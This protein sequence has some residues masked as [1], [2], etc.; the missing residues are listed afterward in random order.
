MKT[1]RYL[2]SLQL[3]PFRSHRLHLKGTLA[4]FGARNNPSFTLISTSESDLLY[5]P[6]PYHRQFL[7]G[8]LLPAMKKNKQAHQ[9]PPLQVANFIQCNSKRRAASETAEVS[10]LQNQAAGITSMVT[11]SALVL[12]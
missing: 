3:C 12:L 4:F 6:I 1:V 2:P 8:R 7:E 5:L 10:P 9:Q 11:L